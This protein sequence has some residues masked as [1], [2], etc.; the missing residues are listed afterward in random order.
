[1][2]YQYQTTA[3]KEDLRAIY[4]K[5]QNLDYVAGWYF[6]AAEYIK[7]TTIRCA[8]VS[9]NSICQGEQVAV[10]WKL[11]IEQYGIHIDFAWPT[12]RWDSEASIKAHVHCVIVGFSSAEYNLPKRIFSGQ[13]GVVAKTIS[14]YLID[15]PTAFI[16]KRT[17][18]ISPVSKMHRGSQPTDDGNFIF[19]HEEYEQFLNDEPKAAPLFRAYMMGKDFIERKPRYCLWLKDADPNL[20]KLPKVHARVEA[21]KQFR[22]KSSKAATREKALTPTLFD[23]IQQ[24]ET[25]FVALPHVSSE[26]RRYIPIDFMTPETV[27]GNKVY[28]IEN[29][30]LYEF[31]VLTSNVHMAWV[32]S[33]CGRLKSDYC[34][35]NTIV[36][37]NF[38]WPSPTPEQRARIEQTAQVILDVRAKYQDKSFSTLYD[39]ANMP[40][41]LRK[42]HQDNDKA[43]M[44]AY[45]FDWRSSSMTESDC[46]AEL[47]RLYEKLAAE[48][49]EK[50]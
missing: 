30:T 21:V 9:T 38:P 16:E 15:A 36:Y 40:P 32:R 37:N 31:G 41:D 14:P 3:Q 23:E 8:L 1:M 26:Q 13:G 47:F 24:P 50:K 4:D 42:A 27:V 49:G 11:L 10:I 35:S 5:A 20:T 34:Y 45:G 18:P 48:K 6:K 19:T 29:A 25:N 33:V 39:D 46:V 12:F 22:E 43:V 17:A 2:G 44:T 7:G 28:V